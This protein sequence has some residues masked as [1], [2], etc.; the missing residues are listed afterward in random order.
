MLRVPVE[1]EA[2]RSVGY[3]DGTLEIEFV[4]GDVYRYF[5]V[6]AEIHRVLLAAESHGEFFNAHVRDRFQY[7]RL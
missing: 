7:I 5:D 4:Q 3:R 1:S 2:M 6:P